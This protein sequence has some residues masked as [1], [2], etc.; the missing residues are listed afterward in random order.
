MQIKYVISSPKIWVNRN[1][2]LYLPIFSMSVFNFIS[3]V[4]FFIFIKYLGASYLSILI[5]LLA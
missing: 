5:M 2:L 4:I 1:I 3:Y